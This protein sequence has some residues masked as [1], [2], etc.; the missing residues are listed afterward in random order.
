MGFLEKNQI[1]A[2][3]Q[4]GFRPDRSCL[5]HIFTLCDLVRTRKAMRLEMF[6]AFVDFQKAFDFVG[7][8]FL[9][10]K[11]LEVGVDGNT[12]NIISSIYSMSESCV[13]VND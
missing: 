5:D 13:L 11:L 8:E 10:H 3:E 9:K 7:H 2:N 6:C 4:N 12:Y 1:L